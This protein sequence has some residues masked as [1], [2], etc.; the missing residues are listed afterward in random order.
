MSSQNKSIAWIDDVTKKEARGA[1][2]ESNFGEVQQV[3]QHYVLTQKGRISKEKFYIP[4]YLVH[5]FDGNT[6]WW[7][8]AS[9]SD[10]ERWKRDSSPDYNEYIQYK[11][12]EKEE[13]PSDIETRIP[14]ME[15][16]LNVLKRISASEATITKE[17]VTKTRL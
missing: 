10:L 2:D 8:N 15:E 14:L 13:V 12:S 5:G 11:K 17:P 1:E 6:L 4:K 9:E 7:F 3:G 16:R